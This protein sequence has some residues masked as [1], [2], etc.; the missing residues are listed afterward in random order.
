[1]RPAPLSA[2]SGNQFLVVGPA[3]LQAALAGQRLALLKPAHHHLR[4]VMHQRLA[5]RRNMAV[6]N[7][8][9]AGERQVA[10]VEAKLRRVDNAIGR[11]I[12][13]HDGL[14]VAADHALEPAADVLM[15]AHARHQRVHAAGLDLG[16]LRAGAQ[17]PAQYHQPVAVAP[18]KGRKH[19]ALAVEPARQADDGDIVVT[20][21]GGPVL[22]ESHPGD[23]TPGAGSTRRPRRADR[24]EQAVR[25]G[26][27]RWRRD[28]RGSETAAG[29][30]QSTR[31]AP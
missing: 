17:K 18:L 1:M 30:R 20:A 7:M 12:H 13:P 26:R 27:R 11:E 3:E 8:A 10:G 15:L 6:R 2:A 9:H 31:A 16:L 4:E 25:A 5:Q 22:R 28:R 14:A 21:R 24:K 23:S 29:C 19:G